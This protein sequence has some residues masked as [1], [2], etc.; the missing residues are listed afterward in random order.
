MMIVRRGRI[1]LSGVDQR[2]WCTVSTTYRSFSTCLCVRLAYP[3]DIRTTDPLIAYRS[4]A[5][6]GM[7]Q[8]DAEQI[9][10]MVEVSGVALRVED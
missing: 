8:E 1:R 7:L 5:A 9:R 6:R 3:T 10:A 4:L 2:T